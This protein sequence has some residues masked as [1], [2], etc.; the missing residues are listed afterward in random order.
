MEFHQNDSKT[1]ESI[2]ETRAIF[3]QAT[4]DAEALCS[5]TVKETKATCTCT[6]QEAKAICST[7]IGDAETWGTC[8]DES[9]HR[10]HA[11]TIKHLEEQVIQ[12]GGKSQIDF[13]SA[14]QAAL[15]ASLA[16]L[17]GALVTSYHILM[18]QAPTSHPFTLSQGASPTEQSSASAA[19]SSLAPEHSPGPKRQHPSPDPVDNRPLGRTTSKTTSEG[20]QHQVVR[21]SP[22]V[23]GTQMGPLRSVQPGH[24]SSEGGQEGVL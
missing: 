23:Q 8:Q 20:P 19:P 7:A 6:V 4:L 10:Q 5:T 24:Q 1:M 11:K 2:K 22:L 15:Q 17:R 18:G 13:L 16:E 21:D 3:T 12:E 9:L 14:C